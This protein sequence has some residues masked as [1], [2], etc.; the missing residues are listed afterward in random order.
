MVSF[1]HMQ[2]TRTQWIG[3][4]IVI[5]VLAA[6]GWWYAMKKAPAPTD[7]T[8]PVTATSSEAASQSTGT[9][10]ST[11]PTV[12]YTG[13]FPTNAADTIASWN[14]KGTYTGNTTLVVQANA[15]IA[16]LT[17][18]MGKGEYDDYDLYL[19]IANDYG[20]MGEGKKAYDNY[21]RSVRIHPAKGLAYANLGNL[22]DELGAYHT[23]A[24]AYAKAATV[25][26]RQLEY[27]L[28]RLNFLIERFSKD[29]VRVS[30]AFADAAK[31]FGDNAQILSIEARWFAAE[32]KYADAIKVLQTV[33]TL[34]PGKDT[35]A[36]DA[37]IARLQAKQ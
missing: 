23:A 29:T 26:P 15:D 17:G 24:D 25:E 21:D 14:F 11:V 18:L 4:I 22:F 27:H 12:T 16:K 31:Q 8:A 1:P 37:Q 33:K 19:G 28:E 36:I 34:S 3:A 7:Q 2:I 10:P 35:T 6:A 30:A 9:A 32:G 20:L 5:I 13:P